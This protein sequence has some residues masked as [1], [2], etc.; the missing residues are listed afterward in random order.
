MDDAN[1]FALDWI[2]AFNAGD[3]PRILSHYAD[4]VEL[5]SPIYLDFTGGESD[6]VSGKTALAGYF[7][8]A[9]TRHPDLRFTLLEVA[10]GTRS[11]CL[12]YHSNVG[13]RIAMECFERDASGKALRVTCHYID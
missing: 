2:A 7:G 10:R 6:Q 12:R 13:D 11:L 3:L 9:L 4:A 5:I 1:D 8:A